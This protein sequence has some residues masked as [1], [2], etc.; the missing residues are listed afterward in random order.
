MASVAPNVGGENYRSPDFK[1]QDVITVAARLAQL[2]AEEVDLL[3]EM[4]VNRIEVL[5]KEKIFLTNAL[6][7]QRKM[8]EKNPLLLETIPSQDKSDMK[9]IAEVFQNILEEN[10][11]KLLIAKEVNHKVVQAIRDVVRESTQSRTYN[12]NGGSGVAAFNTLSVTLN[13][14]I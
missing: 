7:A 1:I 11:R 6:E 9:E 10:H 8:I 5:Q 2:L 12:M 3:T 14:T 13:K 4:K